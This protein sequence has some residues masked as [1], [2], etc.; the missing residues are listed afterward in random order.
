MENIQGSLAHRENL[1]II[2]AERLVTRVSEALQKHLAAHRELSPGMASD[3]ILCSREKVTLGLITPW[4]SERNVKQ[5]VKTLQAND[6]LTPTIILRT[7]CMI[8][9]G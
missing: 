3:L 7:L 4:S 2:V 9:V 5:L 8:D 6:Q 1:P